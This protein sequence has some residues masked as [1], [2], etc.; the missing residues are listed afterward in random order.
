MG[1][2]VS[3]AKGDSGECARLEPGVIIGGSGSRYDSSA[4][5][6]GRVG[7]GEVAELWRCR[8]TIRRRST[9]LQ[10]TCVSTQ[11][12][13]RTNSTY[14]SALSKLSLNTAVTARSI[15]KLSVARVRIFCAAC[16]AAPVVA[17]DAP[18]ACLA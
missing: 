13:R 18:F 5:G 7:G 11:A 1:G 14:A 2:R 3:C 4:E 10:E 12:C 6:G 17:T 16:V 9:H 8:P 15:S